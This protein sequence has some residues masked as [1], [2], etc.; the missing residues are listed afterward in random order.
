M[1][2]LIIDDS[3][4][5]R[6]KLKSLFEANGYEVV[7]EAKNGE[8]AIDL[9]NELEPDVITLDNVLPDMNGLDILNA[10]DM[11]ALPSKVIMISALG[12]QSA[13]V[14]AKGLGVH[15]YLVKPIDNNELI[16]L[17]KNIDKEK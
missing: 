2:I 15:H 3:T 9:V 6:T 13:I 8:I 10:L 14:D 16:E 1:R 5:I 7:G 17:L 11:E 4:F 12:Q